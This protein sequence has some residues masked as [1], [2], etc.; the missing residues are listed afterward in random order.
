M[1]A[2]ARDGRD[3]P[4]TDPPHGVGGGAGEFGETHGASRAS[5]TSDHVFAATAQ[6]DLINVAPP[7]ARAPL[8]P[9]SYW[10]LFDDHTIVHGTDP[11]SDDFGGV[12]FDVPAGKP[13]GANWDVMPAHSQ[14]W[15]EK[16]LG[17]L[18]K[19]VTGGRP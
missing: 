7:P 1:A 8:G 4:G 18:A 6:N 3:V 11:T 10:D 16:P 9:K 14:Y 19:I 13:P 2:P 12:V 17:S 15:D 5:R